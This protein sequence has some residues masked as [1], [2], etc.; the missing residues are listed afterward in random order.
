MIERLSADMATGVREYIRTAH[1]DALPPQLRDLLE[2]MAACPEC[3]R[4]HARARRA[5]TVELAILQLMRELV[6]NTKE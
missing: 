5:A 6:N 1:A 3:Q 4:I 2:D